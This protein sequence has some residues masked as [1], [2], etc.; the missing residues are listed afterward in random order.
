MEEVAHYYNQ[1]NFHIL[2]KNQYFDGE[3]L[4]NPIQTYF[5]QLPLFNISP[6]LQKSYSFF[7]RKSEYELSEGWYSFQK[8]KKGEFY[9]ID[10][11]Q[12]DNGIYLI[13]INFSIDT[14]VDAYQRESLTLFE[15]FGTLGGIFEIMHTCL[16]F[17]IGFYAQ[18]SFKKSILK[19]IK[20][21]KIELR[22]LKN[23]ESQRDRSQLYIPEKDLDVSK[24]ERE[25]IKPPSEIEEYKEQLEE[26]KSLN[27]KS[28]LKKSMAIAKEDHK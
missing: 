1:V 27:E 11:I 17:V 21:G 14:T 13:H 5:K 12:S 26:F 7:I 22:S 20:S 8:P 23:D 10:R 3:N 24:R 6:Y 16:G 18:N 2:I 4:S 28:I 9:S 25:D 19:S 15:A